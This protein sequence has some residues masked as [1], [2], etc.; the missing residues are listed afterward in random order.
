MPNPT[1][2]GGRPSSWTEDDLQTLF[3]LHNVLMLK[4]LAALLGRP[5][6][7]VRWY[8]RKYKL[9]YIRERPNWS[10]KDMARLPWL[11]KNHTV[12]EIAEMLGRSPEGVKV[13]AWKMGLR[14]HNSVDP[15]H[16]TTEEDMMLYSLC[17]QMGVKQA[18]KRIGRSPRG[19][20]DRCKKLKLK[21]HQ[22]KRSINSVAEDLGIHVQTV[23]RLAK[24]L[25]LKLHVPRGSNHGN[26]S[27]EVYEAMM[28]WWFS[29]S[30]WRIAA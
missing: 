10:K 18:A 15:R 26:V 22:G 4:D 6:G 19:V 14:T 12:D 5:S 1:G 27:D 17:T 3:D 30:G 23:Y 28:D 7:T 20:H 25:G 2:K 29:H 13:K 24:K 21:W 16:W 9:D 11:L 8:C